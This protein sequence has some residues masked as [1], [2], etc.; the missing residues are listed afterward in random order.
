MSYINPNTNKYK[1]LKYWFDP[2]VWVRA[3]Y[4]LYLY[5]FIFFKIW[6]YGLTM[7][8]ITYL[9]ETIN[10]AGCVSIK[11][12]QWL[13]QRSDVFGN[14]ITHE[15]KNLQTNCQSHPLEQ[16]LATINIS[17]YDLKI[18][19]IPLAVGSIAQVH[20]ATMNNKA[21]VVKLRH[22]NIV[23]NVEMD[24]SI[25]YR[26]VTFVNIFYPIYDRIPMFHRILNNIYEQVF[27]SNES[28]NLD[29]L[30]TPT[31]IFVNF[32]KI[33]HITDSIIIETYCPGQH[34][35]EIKNN[36]NQYLNARMKIFRSFIEMVKNGF[37]HGDLHDGNI[38]CDGDTVYI[39]D[40]GIMF[41]L[42]YLEKKSLRELLKGYH[43]F[44]YSGQPDGLV[45]SCRYFTNKKMTKIKRDELS[46]IFMKYTVRCDN[47]TLFLSDE[48][49]NLVN[50]VIVFF[51]QNEI[52]INDNI[53]FLLLT[54]SIIEAN[55]T[56]EFKFNLFEHVL[57]M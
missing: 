47:K 9:K 25:I 42:S 38:L 37:I 26:I 15:L 46:N 19:P 29:R 5:L 21:V 51:G 12:S 34:I 14:I 4:L 22:P 53:L 48:I 8:N 56:N 6:Y 1:W 39:I 2:H 55:V 45:T 16:L 32:P 3:T 40:F 7:K 17:S 52:Y 20:R 24:L 49:K 35:S 57:M 28:K 54:L 18:E 36:R 50:D 27:L 44:Y 41:D 11:L 23:K 30:N 33:L 43:N 10:K 13:S 31:N